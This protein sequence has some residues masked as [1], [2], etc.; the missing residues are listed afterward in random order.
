[1]LGEYISSDE[2]NNT[3]KNMVKTRSTRFNVND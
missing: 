1:M 2:K 3:I